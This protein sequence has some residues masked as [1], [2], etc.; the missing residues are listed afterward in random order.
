MKLSLKALALT[1]GILW[2]LALCVTGIFNLIWRGYGDAFL[3]TDGFHL[4]G[5]SCRGLD[6]RSDHRN[7]VCVYRWCHLRVRFRMA[8]QFVS[9]QRKLVQT[10]ICLDL[11]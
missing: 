1:S 5:L 6:R 8:L 3:K 2:A 4:P 11:A 9:W 7:F 10:V